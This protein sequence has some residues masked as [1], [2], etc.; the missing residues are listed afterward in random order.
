MLP[1]KLEREVDTKNH[2]LLE[3]K[4]QEQAAGVSTGETK[5]RTPE[6]ILGTDTYSDSKQQT[7]PN[8]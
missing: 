6:K 1:P 5:T 4:I 7:Q 3:A 8:S 2:S